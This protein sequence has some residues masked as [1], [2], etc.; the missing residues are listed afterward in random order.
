MTAYAAPVGAM[1]FA[2]DLVGQDALAETARF[3][4]ATAETRAAV[5]AEAAR[6]AEEV[7]APLDRVGDTQPARLDNGVVRCPPGFAEGFRAI[8]E[9]GWI[10]LAADPAHGGQ[11]LPQSLQAMV[12]E[13]LASACLSLSIAALLTQSQIEALEAHADPALAAW[14]L[15]PLVAG[16]WTGTMNLSEPQAGSD[17]GAVATRAEPAEDGRFRLTG[18]KIWISYG[19]HDI[20]ENV[21]HLVLARLPDAPS[22]TRG[23]S[24]FAVPKRLPAADGSAGEANAIRTVSLESKLGLHGAP[25]CVLAYE[26]ATGW[27]VGAPHQGMAAMFTMMN[28]ARLGVGLQGIAIAEKATQRAVAYALERR[29]GRTADGSGVIAG[30]PDVRRML[31]EMRALTEAARAIAY[32]CALAI[33]LSRAAASE[34]VRAAHAARAGVLTPIA[35]AFG[36]A[37]GVAVADLGIQVHGGVGYVEETGAAQLLRDVRVTTIY[38][39]TNGIQALDLAGRKLS[40]DEGA[41]M[42]ALIGEAEATAEALRGAGEERMA[43]RLAAAAA[44]AREATAWMLGAGAEDRAAGASPYLSMAA[45]LLGAHHLARGAL[46]DPARRPLAEAFLTRLLPRGEAEAAAAMAGAAALFA[47]DAEALG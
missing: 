18:Q 7:V 15:P 44:G 12:G 5:L 1:A 21:L 22:G 16:R 19:D 35:K 26:G 27:L 3:A 8:A 31:V 10:G 24:L 42:G 17:V 36:T 4:E 34:T 43:A 29:Q 32:D 20:A 46:R 45:H 6:L 11:G 41:A 38:E 33:D 13:M 14:A 40:L 28:S 37:T 2:A 9:G 47:G 39:G 23:I 25:T 30:H